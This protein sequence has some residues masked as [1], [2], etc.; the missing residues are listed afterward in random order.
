[1]ISIEEAL[2]VS[3]ERVTEC[4]SEIVADFTGLI[5]RGEESG[6]SRKEILVAISALTACELSSLPDVPRIH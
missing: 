4:G 2:V 1:M 6:F 5:A 3:Q